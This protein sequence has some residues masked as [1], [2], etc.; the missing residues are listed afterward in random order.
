MPTLVTVDAHLTMFWADT[1]ARISKIA[2]R[3]RSKVASYSRD[4]YG[5]AFRR[6]DSGPSTMMRRVRYDAAKLGAVTVHQD[7]ILTARHQWLLAVTAPDKLTALRMSWP[8]SQR[9]WAVR[10]RQIGHN[11]CSGFRRHE[12]PRPAPRIECPRSNGSPEPWSAPP[13]HFPTA[14][15]QDAATNPASEYLDFDHGFYPAGS[16]VGPAD[17]AKHAP[18]RGCDHAVN[19][20]WPSPVVPARDRRATHRY[21]CAH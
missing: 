20:F 10:M 6:D 14:P 18:R 17:A 7:G 2:P 5:C 19:I 21:V 13:D 9:P 11:R 16:R 15:S 12:G 1:P 4:D 3:S 8:A